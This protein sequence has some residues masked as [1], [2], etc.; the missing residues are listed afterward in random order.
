MEMAPEDMACA[1]GGSDSIKSFAQGVERSEEWPML[2]NSAGED[3]GKAE[4]V[5]DLEE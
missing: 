4:G 3:W 1:S 5:P 2:E